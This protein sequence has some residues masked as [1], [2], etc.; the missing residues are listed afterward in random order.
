LTTV[1]AGAHVVGY[2]PERKQPSDESAVFTPSAKGERSIDQSK[3][4]TYMSP[5]HCKTKVGST[6]STHAKKG[7]DVAKKTVF[8]SDLSGKEI[9]E[10]RSAVISIKFSDARK[11]TYVLDV[12]EDEAEELGSK[13]RKQARRGRRPKSEG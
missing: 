2:N 4:E 1:D 12:T 11:G 3:V 5:A 6:P 8:V 7:R 10:G 13:G 9:P